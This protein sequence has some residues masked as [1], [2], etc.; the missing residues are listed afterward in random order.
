M[1]NPSLLRT[2]PLSVL[3]KAPWFTKSIAL[4]HNTRRLIA[5][6]VAT[7]DHAWTRNDNEPIR[8]SSKTEKYLARMPLVALFRSWFLARVVRSRILFTPGLACLRVIAN[9]NTFLLDPDRN[10]VLRA[11][12]KP[13]IYDQ[14]A[15][16]CAPSQRL[17]TRVMLV[18]YCLTQKR[19]IPINTQALMRGLDPA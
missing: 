2:A 19:Y 5:T 9:S 12:L 8:S 16:S 18:L 17:G 3:Y 1:S 10:P 14:L 15:K 7:A 4:H 13:L 6:K 11:I